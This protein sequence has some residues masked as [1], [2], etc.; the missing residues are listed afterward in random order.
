LTRKRTPPA[1]LP[2]PATARFEEIVEL[3]MVVEGVPETLIP[4]P[5]SLSVTLSDTVLLRMVNVEPARLQAE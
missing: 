1:P 3:V 4:A 5:N 2:L